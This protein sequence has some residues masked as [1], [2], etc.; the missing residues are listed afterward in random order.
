M[1]PENPQKITKKNAKYKKIKEFLYKRN[2]K[3]I[4]KAYPEDLL[5]FQVTDNKHNKQT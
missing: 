4:N 1:V 3:D 5:L 2:Y